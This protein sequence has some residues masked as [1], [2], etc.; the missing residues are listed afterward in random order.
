MND[1]IESESPSGG[2]ANEPTATARRAYRNTRR[3]RSA[4]VNNTTRSSWNSTWSGATTRAFL[5]TLRIPGCFHSLRHTFGFWA[6]ID[7]NVPLPVLRDVLERNEGPMRDEE[8]LRLFREIM[9][10]C[11]AQQEPLKIAYLGPEGTFTQQAVNRH[12]G[13]SVLAIS[14]PSIESVS[15]TRR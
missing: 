9:S 6:A 7:L 3:L 11:L 15:M 12:F 4:A 13:H 5:D 2:A 1:R 10:A 8:M 14:M